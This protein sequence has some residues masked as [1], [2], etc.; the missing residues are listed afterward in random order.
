MQGPAG[1]EYDKKLL[2]AH[3]YSTGGN[4]MAKRYK[5]MTDQE[6]WIRYMKYYGWHLATHMTI[7]DRKN[8]YHRMIGKLHFIKPRKEG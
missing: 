3:N 2:H 1:R 5:N 6:I 4:T 7:L 8:S